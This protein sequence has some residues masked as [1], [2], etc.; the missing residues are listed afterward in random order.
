M[1][2]QA[3]QQT[4]GFGVQFLSAALI[5]P[6]QS[7]AVLPAMKPGTARAFA[8]RRR[9][10]SRAPGPESLSLGSLELMATVVNRALSALIY[11]G[12]IAAAYFRGTGTLALKTAAVFLIPLACIWFSRA[13]G[14]FTGIT[15]FVPITEPTPAV[16]MCA[17]GWLLLV[18]APIMFY[19]I[20]G[21]TSGLT[22]R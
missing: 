21:G 13:M 5:R 4:P 1:A 18:G 6:A 2:Y 22:I 12:Y 20:A 15:P 16:F 10:Q 7:R 19:L 8:L 11:L 14:G 3:L 9:A 17:V